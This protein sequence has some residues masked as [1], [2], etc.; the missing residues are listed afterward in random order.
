MQEFVGLRG[1]A[2]ALQRAEEGVQAKD[3]AAAAGTGGAGV[4]DQVVP[5]GKLRH[6]IYAWTAIG[7]NCVRQEN[8]AGSP[9]VVDAAA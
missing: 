8:T 7:K 6:A 5:A 4:L 1:A 3:V 9:K 2:I